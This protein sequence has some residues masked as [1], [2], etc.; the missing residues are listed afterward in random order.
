VRSIVHLQ[1]KERFAKCNWTGNTSKMDYNAENCQAFK[2][3]FDEKIAESVVFAAAFIIGTILIFTGY[4]ILRAS[5]FIQ[6]FA[7]TATLTHIVLADYTDLSMLLN[8]VCSGFAGLFFGVFSSIFIW[9]GIVFSSMVQGLF[10]TVTTLFIVDVFLTVE[11][12]WIPVGLIIGTCLFLVVLA[13]I[14]QKTF[15]ILF[16]TSFGAICLMMSVDFF[17]D[18]S[19][20]RNTAYSRALLKPIVREPC[21][22]SW[23]L[24]GLWPILMVIGCLV[25]FLKTGKDYDHRETK[26][27]FSRSKKDSNKRLLS[28]NGDIIAQAWIHNA[29]ES[30]HCKRNFYEE[31]VFFPPEEQ[32][33][34][35]TTLV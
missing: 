12:I 8:G 25:Q 29:V 33:L 22:F 20:L 32:R 7:L 17:L 2:Y 16:V 26:P 30:P 9:F 18:L 1:Q 31:D 4:R 15:A 5:L 24:Y 23:T 21:W 19:M 3:D 27:W 6:A 28:D 10:L 14:W 13:L 35:S 34:A 11:T